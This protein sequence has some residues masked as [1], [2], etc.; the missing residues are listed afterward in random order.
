MR[1]A[2]DTL[3]T[4]TTVDRLSSF[5]RGLDAYRAG[6]HYEAHELWEEI[7]HDEADDHRRALLQALIQIASAVHK[8]RNDVAPRGSLRLIERALSHLEGLPPA[9]MG[10]DIARLRNDAARFAT[11]VERVL[12]ESGSCRIAAELVPPIAMLETPSSWQSSHAQLVPAAARSS[13]FDR[14]LAAY[15]QRDFFEAHE[16]W[17]ELWRDEQ[18]ESHKRFLQ[19]L[20]QVAAAMHKIQIQGKPAPALRLLARAQLR[21]APFPADYFGLR[22]DRLLRGSRRAQQALQALAHAGEEGQRLADELVPEITRGD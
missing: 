6:D 20:I 16:L 10:V 11:Q 12:L 14:G 7:W 3:T 15:R 13:W 22:V 18:D 1:V 19:G 4:M 2:W 8:A 5:L 9:F 17:E 21:L